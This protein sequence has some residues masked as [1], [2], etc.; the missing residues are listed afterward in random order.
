M[1]QQ[2]TTHNN[3]VN[4]VEL[5]FLIILLIA[6]AI[7]A[8]IIVKDSGPDDMIKILSIANNMADVVTI[9][10]YTIVHYILYIAGLIVAATTCLGL[11]II[12]RTRKN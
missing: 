10:M 5:F 4:L 11:I 2:K 8:Y 12:I 6:P 7:I 9:L 1:E 3:P